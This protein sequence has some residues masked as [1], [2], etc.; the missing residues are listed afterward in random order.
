MF[1]LH[2]PPMDFPTTMIVV[3]MAAL[4]VGNAAYFG[5]IYWSVRRAERRD[6]AARNGSAT[7]GA[8]A[9]GSK[10]DCGCKHKK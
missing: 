1:G 2:F 3:L 9:P 7:E 5:W 4:I 10:H 8:A 6:N